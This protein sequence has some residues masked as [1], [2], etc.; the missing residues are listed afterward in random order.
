MRPASRLSAVRGQIREPQGA[1]STL[2]FHVDNLYWTASDW[3]AS[4]GYVGDSPQSGRPESASA[5][6]AQALS[7]E[8]SPIA[9]TI[10]PRV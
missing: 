5:V 6:G 8:A 1:P 2:A 9:R 10:F 4:M 3:H 7:R